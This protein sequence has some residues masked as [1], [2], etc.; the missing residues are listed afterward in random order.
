MVYPETVLEAVAGIIDAGLPDHVTIATVELDSGGAH[1]DVSLP[2]VELTVQNTERLDLNTNRRAGVTNDAGETIG[3]VHTDAFEMSLELELLAVEGQPLS[4]RTL[5]QRVEA[6]VRRY[7]SQNMG[8]TLP[9][10]ETG[11]PLTEVDTVRF[12]ER[13]PAND[14]SLNYSLRGERFEVTTRFTHS[15]STVD[16]VGEQDP[17]RGFDQTVAVDE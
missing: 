7:D 3:Y 12:G 4:A 2:L 10:P 5:A 11:D 6:A 16:V 8:E 15:F 17:I 1:A 13:Q 9:H 14:F